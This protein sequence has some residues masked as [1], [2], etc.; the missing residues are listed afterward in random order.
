MQ[1]SINGKQLDLGAAFRE[2]IDGQLPLVFDKYFEN[3]TEGN[4]T[5]SK[6]GHEVRADVTVH[7]GKGLLHGHAEARDSYTVFD[8]AVEQV[9]KRLRRFKRRLHNY[10]KE[11]PDTA[12]VLPAL[13]YVFE[14]VNDAVENSNEPG[15]PVI[16][17]ELD[18][19]IEKLTP[20]GAVMRIDFANFPASMFRNVSHGGLNMVY[21]RSDGN[22]SWVDPRGERG[23]VA[24]RS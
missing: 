16:V 8:K 18:T 23:G 21:R 1:L 2:Y 17:A 4:E 13:Q 10:P 19:E 5:M 6:Q 20:G 22:I 7:V 3:P 12:D 11:R 14:A 9:G 15:Q 24:E